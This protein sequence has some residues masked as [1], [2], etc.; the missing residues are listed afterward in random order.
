MKILKFLFVPW[1]L[2]SAAIAQEDPFDVPGVGVSKEAARAAR[3]TKVDL[4]YEI[5]SLPTEK[6]AALMRAGH[7]DQRLYR[8]L[9]EGI[10]KNEVI[11]ESF[12]SLASRS[13]EEVTLSDG[14]RMIYPTEWEM[15][16]GVEN[17][18]NLEIYEDMWVPPSP[19]S[20]EQ[21]NLGHGMTLLP[22]LDLE[23]G[24]VY[25]KFVV[26]EVS[27]HTLASWMK[28]ATNAR[29]PR[30]AVSEIKSET[31]I[32]SGEV[33]L[34]GTMNHGGAKDRSKRTRLAF[35]RA[36]IDGAKPKAA[37]NWNWRAR[38]E[39]FSL[40]AGVA[41][42]MRRKVRGGN[43][44]AALL[45]W[46]KPEDRKL[47][48]LLALSTNPGT[49]SSIDTICELV[50]PTE[51]DP[52]GLGTEVM[53]LVPKWKANSRAFPK[54]PFCFETKNV[55]ETLELEFRADEDEIDIRLT[56]RNVAFSGKRSI[57]KGNGAWEMPEFLV[58][59]V[60]AGLV[61]NPDRPTLI[62]TANP[63]TQPGRVKWVFLTMTREE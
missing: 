58:S 10:D 27:L 42:E 28:W 63:V 53:P 41:A 45:D 12:H 20:F 30:F 32:R 21:K 6:A 17:P 22:E 13:G 2:G 51:Y 24:L 16:F 26:W 43:L 49:S 15:A 23:A 38:Y 29:V 4:V 36:T 44:Y 3:K 31:T 61:M 34:L 48:Q 14:E 9:I 18:P 55:G 5:F 47:E 52:P 11:Q 59:P 8:D 56:G 25:V 54:M 19:S 7:S 1:V 50:Y 33:R 39:V 40:P 35:L 60:K 57:G 37:I 46:E 62:G